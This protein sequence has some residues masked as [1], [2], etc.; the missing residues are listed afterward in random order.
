MTRVLGM[1]R[2]TARVNI[3]VLL[4]ILTAAGL[5]N[6]VESG[7]LTPRARTLIRAGSVGEFYKALCLRLFSH[8]PWVFDDALPPLAAV[9]LNGL[10]LTYAIA[11]AVDGLSAWDLAGRLAALSHTVRVEPD[12][13][14]WVSDTTT[15]AAAIHARFLSRVGRMLGLFE[16]AGDRHGIMDPVRDALPD[17][18]T[19]PA[20]LLLAAVM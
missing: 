16:E 18:R 7:G 19:V 11:S 13:S 2:E 14:Y 15:M 3:G 17:N 20:D 12:S 8:V 4:T 1:D 9:Q 10:F 6:P 5:L